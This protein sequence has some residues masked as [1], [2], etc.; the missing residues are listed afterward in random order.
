MDE[1]SKEPQ[2]LAKIEKRDRKVTSIELDQPKR[3]T[4]VDKVN[5][6]G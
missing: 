1:K 4:L 6:V 5:K 3:F 2:D